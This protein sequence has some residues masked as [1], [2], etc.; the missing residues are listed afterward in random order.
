MTADR[1][2]ARQILQHAIESVANG[3]AGV[4]ASSFA[5]FATSFLHAAEGRPLQTLSLIHI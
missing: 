1:D 4:Q 2:E 5:A 3:D